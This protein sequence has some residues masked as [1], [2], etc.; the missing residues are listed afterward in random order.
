MNKNFEKWRKAIVESY[1]T[2]SEMHFHRC[3][4][5]N[6]LFVRDVLAQMLS[7]YVDEGQ[8]KF[9]VTLS[10]EQIQIIFSF[11]DEMQFSYIHPR[12]TSARVHFSQ[13]KKTS[14]YPLTK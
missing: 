3:S 14:A 1:P 4:D 7:K 9:I 5:V 6:F 11:L 13:L 2:Q 12:S 8:R 10:P